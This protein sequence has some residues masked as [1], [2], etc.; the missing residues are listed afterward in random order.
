MPIKGPSAHDLLLGTFAIGVFNCGKNNSTT[1]KHVNHE[2]A[3]FIEN[4][5][6][7][8]NINGRSNLIEMVQVIGMEGT[9]SCAHLGYTQDYLTPGICSLIEP[10]AMEKLMSFPTKIHTDM[11]W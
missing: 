3:D 4:H 10:N 9:V 5:A 8:F 1:I 7:D 6:V 2:S 11:L